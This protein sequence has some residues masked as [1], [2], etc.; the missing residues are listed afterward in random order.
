[1]LKDK[2]IFEVRTASIDGQKVNGPY[3]VIH[4]ENEIA[5]VAMDVFDDKDNV[6]KPCIG[7]GFIIEGEGHPV[8]LSGK[9]QWVILPT[10]SYD[11]IIRA[12]IKIK[13]EEYGEKVLSFFHG[14]LEGA[15]LTRY[16]FDS[17][18]NDESVI[19]NNSGEICDSE[20]NSPLKD[21]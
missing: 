8:S 21:V 17:K 20:T 13:D 9:P 15:D 14:E 3:A 2:D 7:M 18:H 16:Y 19:L 11:F 10:E 5:L 4:S 1:M 6:Y 12:Y